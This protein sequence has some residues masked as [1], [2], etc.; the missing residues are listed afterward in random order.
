MER[1]K[2]GIKELND[3]LGGGLPLPSAVLVQGKPGAGKLVMCLQAAAVSDKSKKFM[4][5][6]NNTAAEVEETIK[7]LKL[8]TEID[9]VDCYSWLSGGKSEVDSLANL[10][11]LLLVVEDHLS[12]G[13][14]LVFCSLTPLVLY[15]DEDAVARFLQELIAIV[16]SNDSVMLAVL[17]LGTYHPDAENTFQSLCD[18]VL[19]LDAE[20]GLR[21]MKM[22]DTKTS[23]K[24]YFYEISSKGFR[25]RDK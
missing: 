2:T 20:K 11:K 19:H 16:K 15:N 1:F 13:S 25:L 17:D 12:K 21:V 7:D 9:F 23:D 4:V 18:G 6:T 14:F 24:D 22:R 3:V 8:K 5:L 10:N